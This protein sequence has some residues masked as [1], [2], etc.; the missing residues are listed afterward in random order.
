MSSVVNP[1]DGVMDTVLAVLDSASGAT[2]VHEILVGLSRASEEVVPWPDAG[3]ST[4]ETVNLPEEVVHLDALAAAFMYDYFAPAARA[5]KPFREGGYLNRAG[6]RWPP[7]LSELPAE[8]MSIW[9]R[10]A[11]VAAAPLARARLH[12]L[13]FEARRGDALAQARAA[14]EAYLDCS[15]QVEDSIFAVSGVSWLERALE[16][17]RAIGRDGLVG[18]VTERML[19]QAEAALDGHEWTPGVTLGM[20]EPLVYHRLESGETSALLDRA[21]TVYQD[22]PHITDE[23]LTMIRGQAS[24]VTER[25]AVDRQRVQCWL[26]AA[27]RT[28]G[29]VRHMHLTKAAKLGRDLGVTD[30]ATDVVLALQATGLDDLGLQPIGVVTTL[31]AELIESFRSLALTASNLADALWAVV[32]AGPPAGDSEHNRQTLAEQRQTFRFASLAIPLQL[33][34]GALPQYSPATAEAREEYELSQ[35]EVTALQ[36]SAGLLEVALDA[37]QERFQ[38]SEADLVASFQLE[39]NVAEPVARSLAHAFG[40]YWNNDPEAAC[41]VALPRIESLARELLKAR[42]GSVFYVQKGPAAGQMI[43]LD[44]LLRRLADHVADESWSRSLQTLLVK[45]G[46]GL[47]LRNDILHGLPDRPPSRPEAAL[48]LQAALFLLS[49]HHN[50]R[51]LRDSTRAT[52]PGRAK[53]A[54][55]GSTS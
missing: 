7:P 46:I 49:L 28:A 42:G 41:T 22:D 55:N 39:P 30:L 11:A 44:T 47:N 48:V 8:I 16:L 45:P 29:L 37:V 4:A 12:D 19:A 15:T 36:V 51:P 31:P 9:E 40:H 10:Y 50:Q 34:Y 5:G 17:C 23:V 2:D 18:R 14:F 32:D 24:T 26:D 3:G 38:P 52:C 1:D 20:L 13:L 54:A 33:N 25:G 21:L 27:N 43:T 6:E 35:L 53:P